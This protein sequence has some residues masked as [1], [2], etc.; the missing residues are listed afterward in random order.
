MSARTARGGSAS[1]S[2]RSEARSRSNATTSISR[3][4]GPGFSPLDARLDLPHDEITARAERFL[5]QQIAVLPYRRAVDVTGL[6]GWTLSHAQAGRIAE[7]V[8]AE[9]HSELFGPDAAVEA[10][11][12]APANPAELLVLGGDG[13]RYRTNEADAPRRTD[14]TPPE[15]RGWRENKV[16]VVARALPGKT[17]EDGSYTAP[18]ELVKTYV[19]TTRTVEEFGRDL[20]I[21]ADRRGLA[22]AREV[23]CIQDNG[24]GLPAMVKREF[25]DVDVNCVTDFYHSAERLAEVARLVKGDGRRA[26]RARKRL[27]EKLRSTLWDGRL[28]KLQKTLKRFASR[29]APRPETLSQLDDTPEARKLWEHVFYFEQNAGT[30][31]YP[32]YRA[33]GW[34]IGSGTVESACGRFGLRVKRTCM[35]WTRRVADSVHVIMAA[36]FSEDERWTARWPGKVPILR[37]A[38]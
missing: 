27:F 12:S 23:V 38:A 25:G 31:R 32:E 15:D 7:R 17:E 18:R 28:R 33:K 30:M 11:S 34:P 4:W 37:A 26:E 10:A 6:F 24:H 36:I 29:L 20:R 21:E 9:M 8:G 35:R 2:R 13:S 19:A 22:R 1:A 14:E 5:L 16:G 3:T